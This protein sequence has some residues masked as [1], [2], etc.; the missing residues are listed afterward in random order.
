MGIDR[1]GG[2]CVAELAQVESQR[3]AAVEH[4]D[5]RLARLVGLRGVR[6]CP[7]HLVH[8]DGRRFDAEGQVN[9]DEPREHHA[10]LR[11][12][13][14]CPAGDAGFG[15]GDHDGLRIAVGDLVDRFGIG[16]R[17]EAAGQAQ[18]EGIPDNRLTLL[19]GWFLGGVLGFRIL[20]GIFAR[21]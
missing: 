1:P 18:V 17:L 3:I 2:F 7:S 21:L 6:K 9:L 14:F 8:K 19:L 16:R 15:G 13:D 4:A 11:V 10:C 12:F 20:A 5:V